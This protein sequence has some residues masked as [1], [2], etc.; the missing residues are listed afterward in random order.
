MTKPNKAI[1]LGISLI[2]IIFLIGA[3]FVT[4]YFYKQEAHIALLCAMTS[5]HREMGASVDGV[6][7]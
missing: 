2:P 5:N 4:I 3:L 6:P 7:A 1:P